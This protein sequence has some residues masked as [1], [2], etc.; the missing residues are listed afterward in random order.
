MKIAQILET[1]ILVS[2]IVIACLGP[3]S[4]VANPSLEKFTPQ[5]HPQLTVTRSPGKISIDG[6]LSDPGWK[7]AKAACNFTEHSPGEE[8][9]PPVDTRVFVTYDNDNLY[10]AAICYADP[11]KVR[12]SMCERE[13]IFDDDN[14]GFF[15]DTYG[16]GSRAY[17]ININPHGIQYD[18]LWSAGWGEDDNFDMI[19]E[20]EGMITDS[21]YQVELAIPFS[22]LRFPNKPKQ[23]WK[24]D[25]YRHHQREVHYSMSWATYDQDEPCWP[26]KWG[27]IYGIENVSPGHGIEILPSFVAHQSGEVTDDNEPKSTFDNGDIFGDLSVGA[28]YAVSSNVTAEAAYNPD[29]SQIEADAS[30]IDVN[31]T[32]ALFYDEKRPF[33]QEGMDLFRTNFNAVYTRSINDPDFAV[34]SSINAGSTNMAFLSAHDENSPIIVPFEEKSATI[35]AGK[36][37]TNMVAMRHA[38]GQDD[39]IRAV[40]TDR[41]FEGGGSG[42]LASLDG[43]LRL[44]KSLSLRSQF[45]FTH[46]DEADDER[47]SEY[48]PDTTFD[49]G[50]RTAAFDGESYSGSAGLVGLIWESRKLYANVR[51]YQRTPTYRAS[52]GYQPRNSD[53]W[54]LGDFTYSIRPKG[55]I[56]HRMYPGLSVGRI[57]NFDG[58]RKDEW[59]R[60]DLSTDFRFAQSGFWCEYMRSTE[61][62]GGYEFAGIW[63]ISGSA[64]ATLTRAVELGGNFVYGRQLARYYLA[65]GTET[66]LSG[67]IDVQP[68][69]R[70]LVEPNFI[71]TESAKRTSDGLY[72]AGFLVRT[73]VGY[74]FSRELSLRLVG[75]YSS[76][77]KQWSV[78]PLITYR[79]NPFS[80]F[81]IGASYDYDKFIECGPNADR[82]VT[83]LSQR[84]FFMKIQYLFQT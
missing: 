79:L 51:T 24:F 65:L 25:F 60:I 53:R 44:L 77:S 72:Y 57:W 26:C 63:A 23:E 70:L 33:F 11:A 81:Y 47:L 45:M 49:G 28:K 62:L 59:L 2:V 4:A 50:K 80:T 68:T 56:I 16:D 3:T 37:Y 20:S 29:F 7:S 71:Y 46:T 30:Q 32:F 14:I 6:D 17:I 73:R 39:H 52:N 55:T 15:F 84:Q 5:Y 78:D 83:C 1:T 48:L 66:T 42:T 61:R 22:S 67:W 12:A 74:Q 27:T 13:R 35:P 8:V 69:D 64:W 40:V 19:F 9:R 38:F 75:E 10:L 43:R 18:A 34:K 54:A 21:G 41:R 76:F 82:T 58:V 31:T 36:S